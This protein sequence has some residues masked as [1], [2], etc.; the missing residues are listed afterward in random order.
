[1][2]INSLVR[3]RL[4]LGVSALAFVS[5]LI[6][7]VYAHADQSI[8][9]RSG[10]GTLGGQDAQVRFVRYAVSQDSPSTDADFTAAQA[11]AFAYLGPPNSSYITSAK[12]SD[13][14]AQWIGT[15][16]EL[17]GGSALYAI[18]FMITDSVIAAA[19]LNLGYSVDNAVHGVYL[20]GTEISNFV[21]DGDYHGEYYYMRSDIASLLKPNA[22][23]WL[24]IKMYDYAGLSAL[25]FSATITTQGTTPGAPTITPNQGGNAGSVS[26]QI[27]AGGFEAGTSPQATV[28]EAGPTVVLSGPGTPIT[29][30]SVTVLSPNILTGT[31]D[32]TKATPG[33]G[34]VTVTNRDGTSVSMPNAFTV[35]AGGAADVVVQPVGTPAV[36]GRIEWFFI[37]VN[38]F[39]TV[40]SGPTSV[41]AALEPWSTFIAATPVPTTI[42]SLVFPATPFEAMLNWNIS[43]LPPGKAV[44]LSYGVEQDPTFPTGETVVATACTSYQLSIIRGDCE[45]KL[46]VN[47][48]LEATKCSGFPDIGESCVQPVQKDYMTFAKC[49][50]QEGAKCG[51]SSSNVRASLDPNDLTG[52]TGYGAQGWF[53]PVSP[54]QYTLSFN[55]LPTATNPA[56]NVYVTNTFDANTLDL[57]TLSVSSVSMGSASYP[58]LN[59]PLMVRP[60]SQDIDL[61]NA[62]PAQNLIV[63]VN[64]SLD[65]TTGNVNVSFLSLDPSTGLE[66]TDATVGFLPPG[67]GGAVLFT[68]KPKPSLATG[69]TIQSSGS[70]IF[71][72]NAA[73][74]TNTWLNTVD[75]TPPVSRVTAMPATEPLLNFPVSWSGTDQG[76]GI[77]NYSIYVSDNGGPFTEWLPNSMGTST[78]YPGVAGHIYAFY[79]IAIDN[80]DNGEAAKTAA[81]T[82]TTV[83]L[84]APTVNLIT[85]SSTAFP[86]QSVTLTAS[87]VTPTGLTIVPTGMIS[88]VSGGNV[89]GS[90]AL[91][92]TGVASITVVLPNGNATITAQYGGDANYVASTSSAVSVSVGMLA[93]TTS[94]AASVNPANL[95]TNVTLTAM[96]MAASG[97]SVPT[98]TITFSD[99]STA[100]GTG[101]LDNT[102]KATY[103]SSSLSAGAHSITA[104]YSGDADY[105]ASTSP[106][107]AL[108]VNAPGF[109]LTVA[110]ASLTIA[111]GGSGQATVTLTPVG[112]FNT[113]VAFSCTGL[114]ANATCTFAPT[115][116]TPTSSNSAVTSM[117]TIATNVQSASAVQ[118]KDSFDKR[119]P[120]LLALAFLG[121]PTVIVAHRRLKKSNWLLVPVLLFAALLS[122]AAIGLAGCG[123][124]G[125][126]TPTGPTTPKGTSTVTV[127]ATSGSSTQTAALTLTVN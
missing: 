91:N 123:G 6:T 18:P 50:Q 121:L 65:Q 21:N 48:T 68:A 76:S 80:V 3:R 60:F 19:T 82:T 118:P 72:T 109:T 34:T 63:R 52:P 15:T 100:L 55:N 99:G 35:T 5:M 97:S 43:N 31:F 88:F 94:I 47:L 73:I 96:V 124:S 75:V 111:D 104:A 29:A 79:S 67:A 54:F 74:N 106:A 26:F 66:P 17:G 36:L 113:Q 13:P 41:T 71:D 10:N 119:N 20:N 81:E 112:G 92:A 40:D 37:D 85:S 4:T 61:R 22:T 28:I 12:F 108:A 57:S 14:L 30:T 7:T 56:T 103:S 8:Q 127:T 114:P 62:Q 98:G 117:V 126:S 120:T 69:T 9:L 24:Y 42:D 83:V 44:I 90:S 27:V 38:N 101:A 1:M 84:P 86:G 78:A 105:T 64:A 11:G 39:G 59:I 122:V 95:G 116:L 33:T 51:G 45:G 58:S 87:I 32:L 107:L 77:A 53:Q 125:K 49:M 93:T 70:V 102:G 115:T 46:Q 110:P 2:P 16:P 25:M 23:N 89:L